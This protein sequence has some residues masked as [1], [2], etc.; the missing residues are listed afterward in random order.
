MYTDVHTCTF[1]G[2]VNCYKILNTFLSL[3]S[4]KMLIIRSRS[5]NSKQER[6]ALFVKAFL[7]WK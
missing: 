1:V 6:L 3:F 7:V 5:Q 4:N 2:Y